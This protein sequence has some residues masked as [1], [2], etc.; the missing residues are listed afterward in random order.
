MAAE[1][2]NKAKL[3]TYTSTRKITFTLVTAKF[4]HFRSK[5]K[6][7][8]EKFTDVCLTRVI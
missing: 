8:I 7:K 3:E 4:Q 6:L 2:S 1:N 5:C